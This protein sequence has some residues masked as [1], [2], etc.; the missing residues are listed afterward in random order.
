MTE[1][2]PLVARLVE[3]SGRCAIDIDNLSD[4]LDEPGMQILFCGGD[5]VQHP[6]CLDV[7]VVLPE[8]AQQFAG[9]FSFAVAAPT[10]EPALRANYGIQH[11]PTLLCLRDGE[12]VGVIAGMQD[13]SIYTQRLASLL[14]APASR[15]PSIG[16]AVAG[17]ATHSTH[18]H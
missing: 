15:A 6:E 8:L 14:E 17:S 7:A 2:H 18:C 3:T 4:F 16:I 1:F 13:W 11:W 10:L 12:Y 5:P 9:R